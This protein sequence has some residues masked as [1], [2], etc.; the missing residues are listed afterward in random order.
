MRL[1]AEIKKNIKSNYLKDMRAI[2]DF[3][4]DLPMNF[5]QELSVHIYNEYTQQVSFLRGKKESFNGFICPNFQTLVTAPE[6]YIFYE[7]EDIRDIYFM[8]KGKAYMIL[9]QYNCQ[10]FI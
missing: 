5:R 8:K 10:P 9:P 2:S 7:G 4:A 3:V 6:E 1:Y